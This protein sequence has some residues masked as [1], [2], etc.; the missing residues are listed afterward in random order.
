MHLKTSNRAMGPIRRAGHEVGS[1]VRERPRLTIGGLV[2]V[3]AL[4]ALGIWLWPELQ[5][6]IRIHRM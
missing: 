3:G 4:V 5:R 6:T 1:L 2:A